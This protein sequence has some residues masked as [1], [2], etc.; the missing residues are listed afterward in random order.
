VGTDPDGFLSAFLDGRYLYF[1][2]YYN[3]TDRHGELLR[4]DTRADFKSPSSW[5]AF[6]PGTAGVG[7]D[8]DGYIG[9]VFDG[10][11][12][13]F[14]AYYN[15]TVYH[16]EMLRYDTTGADASFKLLWSRPGQSGGYCGSP[17]GI[18]AVLNTAQRA[19][20]V[21]TNAVDSPGDW[22]HVAM[23]YD[24]A[25][26]SLYVDGAL[27]SSRAASGGISAS[28]APVVLGSFFEAGRGL[29]GS[30]DEV[31]MYQRALSPEEI[32]AHC[33]RRLY[34]AAEPTVTAVGPEEDR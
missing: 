17:F 9:A 8:T 11:Y 29:L 32:L 7:I 16:S 31:R 33:Q 6:D 10:R 21:S 14:A 22:R 30:L 27:A 34:A 20:S 28:S 2:S 25:L 24:G 5:V 19:F 1:V 4:Y 18:T 26:L 3:G 12:A 13:Y 15:G 23:T